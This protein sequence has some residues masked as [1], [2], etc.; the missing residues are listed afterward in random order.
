MFWY[1]TDS[2]NK[3]GSTDL[4][5]YVMLSKFESSLERFSQIAVLLMWFLDCLNTVL[6]ILV[7]IEISFNFYSKEISVS[8]KNSKEILLMH[9]LCN[10]CFLSW[11]FLSLLHVWIKQT[12]NQS[13]TLSTSQRCVDRKKKF[14]IEKQFITGQWNSTCWGQV[15]A[16]KISS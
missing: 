16:C 4:P 9:L 14:K 7:Y 8:F 15:H 1:K 13:K 5:L 2:V 11:Y 3:A 10:C 12:T 6:R